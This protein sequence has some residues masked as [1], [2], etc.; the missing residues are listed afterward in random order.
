MR[1]KSYCHVA[2]TRSLWN[3]IARTSLPPLVISFAHKQSMLFELSY[4]ELFSYPEL[5]S[6]EIKNFDK[7][8]FC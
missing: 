3:K 5:F 2:L 6:M 1:R 4:F 7:V 8:L